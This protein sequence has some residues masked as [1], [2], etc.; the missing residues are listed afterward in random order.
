MARP[1]SGEGVDCFIVSLKDMMMFESSKLLLQLSNLLSVRHH[2]GVTAVWLPH[3]LVDG[4]LRVIADVKLLDPK[5]SG[6]A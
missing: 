3:D 5:L 1:E 4:E 2:A 6:D